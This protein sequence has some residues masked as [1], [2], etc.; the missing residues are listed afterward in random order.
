MPC[1][2]VTDILTI[3][4]DSQGVVKRYS[5]RKQTCGGEVGRQALIGKWLH[6]RPVEE[7]LATPSGDFVKS[8]PNVSG[9]WEYLLLKHFLA[10]QSGLA[11]ALGRQPGGV[12]EPCVLESLTFDAEGLELTALIKSDA[13]TSK[14]QA[15]RSCCGTK[16]SPADGGHAGSQQESDPESAGTER[17]V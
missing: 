13:V 14:I 15:C 3:A 12:S 8:H 10:V 9:T 7:V 6:G 2:D 1:G 16:A 5:L 17:E 4:V 11:V